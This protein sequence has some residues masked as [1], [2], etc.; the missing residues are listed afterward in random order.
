MTDMLHE[1]FETAE[2]WREEA[3]AL[4]TILL[5]C[6]LGEDLKW[7]KPCYSHDGANICIIQRMTGFLALLFFKG[8][9]IRDEAGILAPQGPNARA[10][11]RA[12]FTSVADVERMAG[13][14]RACV[15][16]AIEVEKRGL[17][18]EKP[19]PGDLDLPDELVDACD[20]DPD[21]RTAFEALTPGRQRGYVL[22]VA[23][24]KQSATRT[25]RIDKHRARIMAGKGL[26]DR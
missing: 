26:H 14:I 22:H 13:D 5:D 19:D 12:T 9:L 18:V 15:R 16:G 24:A 1:T 11:Y 10:G 7:G 2:L 4:R 6:G 20:D 21:L 23:G 25:A 17:K 8:A 3:L